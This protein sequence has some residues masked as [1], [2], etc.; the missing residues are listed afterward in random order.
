M[1]TV[2]NVLIRFKDGSRRSFI[3]DS[4]NE[5]ENHIEIYHDGKDMTV[6]GKST[7]LSVDHDYI[8]HYNLAESIYRFVTKKSKC[9]MGAIKHGILSR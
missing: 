2:H 8:N 6:Y 7:L 1:T 9:I 3:A 4:F 5:V